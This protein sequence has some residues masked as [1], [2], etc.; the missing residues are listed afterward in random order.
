M[1]L[2]ASVRFG[3]FDV[4]LL[5]TEVKRLWPAPSAAREVETVLIAVVSVA[6]AAD[7]SPNSVEATASSRSLSVNGR[8]T[9][10]AALGPNSTVN[11]REVPARISRRLCSEERR[12]G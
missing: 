3:A 12:G 11:V 9:V 5:T 4:R 7:G 8:S 2:R 1:R 6:S 10:L